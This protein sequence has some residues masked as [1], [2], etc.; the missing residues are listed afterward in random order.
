MGTLIADKAYRKDGKRKF[1][2]VQRYKKEV[3]G[4]KRENMNAILYQ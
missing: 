1:I 3:K 2:K 4:C